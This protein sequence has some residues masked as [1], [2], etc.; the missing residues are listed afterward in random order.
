MVLKNV[1]N[2]ISIFSLTLLLSFACLINMFIS[3]NNVRLKFLLFIIIFFLIICISLYYSLDGLVMV[4]VVCE[5]SIILVFITLYAQLITYTKLK[6]RYS[7]FFFFMILTP[8][9]Y[10]FFYCNLTKHV[11]YYSFYKNVINDFYCLFN[12]YF[13]KSIIVTIFITF[14]ITIYSVYFILFYFI[15]KKNDN[16]EKRK[17]KNLFLL[18]KQNIIKQGNYKA[19]VRVFQ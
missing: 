5:L 12:C 3:Q 17:Y 7:S 10:N 18:R 14:V 11:N 8:L 13:E 9:N 19:K 15:L 6:N 1:I 16:W 4:F 2:L